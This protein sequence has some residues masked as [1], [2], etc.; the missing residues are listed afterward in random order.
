MV[1]FYDHVIR[2]LSTIG[3]A[4]SPS[5]LAIQNN[6]NLSMSHFDPHMF[7]HTMSSVSLVHTANG[8]SVRN[9]TLIS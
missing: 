6:S 4:L 2:L 1:S 9:G 8:S 5:P 3:A 7:E